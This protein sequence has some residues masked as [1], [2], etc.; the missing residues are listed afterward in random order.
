M[1]VGETLGTVPGNEILLCV[2]ERR[3][4]SKLFREVI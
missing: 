4:T 2:V 3:T 1:T